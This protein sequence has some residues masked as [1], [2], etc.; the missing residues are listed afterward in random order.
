MNDK[1]TWSERGSRE[2]VANQKQAAYF[3]SARTHSLLT[4]ETLGKEEGVGDGS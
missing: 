4:G 2:R 1:R 3:Q